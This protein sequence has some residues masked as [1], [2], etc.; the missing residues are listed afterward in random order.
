MACHQFDGQISREW[1]EMS[2]CWEDDDNVKG[3][4]LNQTKDNGNLRY[5]AGLCRIS[6]TNYKILCI[7]YLNLDIPTKLS[8]ERAALTD[9]PYHGNLLIP[10]TASKVLRTNVSAGLGLYGKYIDRNKSP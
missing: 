3:F 1:L 4:M 2:I 6:L 10:R 9:N 5:K 7:Q 8:Y